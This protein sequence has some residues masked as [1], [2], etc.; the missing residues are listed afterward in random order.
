MSII[1][2]DQTHKKLWNDYVAK[3]E[4]ST[5]YHRFEW[6]GIIKETYGHSFFYLLHRDEQKISGI[7][8]L[9]LVK[10]I[11]SGQSLISLPFCNYG[12]ILAESAQIEK[13]L[14][15]E[16]KIIAKREKSDCLELRQADLLSDIIGDKNFLDENNVS[17]ILDMPS[18]DGELW[19]IFNPQIRNCIR[20]GQKADLKIKIN[21]EAD[22]FY[23]I[24]SRN[25]RDLGSPPH[26]INLF[27]N[28][29]KTFPE[30]AVIL[31]AWL[32]DKPVASIFLLKDRETLLGPW[33]SSDKKYLSVCPNN[34]LYWEAFKY[35]IANNLK[36]F[37]FE[38]SQRGSGTYV[39]KAQWGA[40][41][42]P[43]FYYYFGNNLKTTATISEKKKKYKLFSQIWRHLPVG[44]TRAIGPSFRKKIP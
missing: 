2:C 42:S 25:M 9:I 36:H 28:I 33:A 26:H 19:N 18:S 29:L 40:K 11:I 14:L 30:E 34:F 6:S 22:I 1:Y 31:T 24:Y 10:K 41:K 5:F 27:K 23:Q 13:E 32:A 4:K 35:A 16:A 43:L 3:R 37:N 20:K 12:G 15:N 39:F 44:I 38:R 7:L 17:M 8:P 21:Q